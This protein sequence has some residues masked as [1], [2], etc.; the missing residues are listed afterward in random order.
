MNGVT[1]SATREILKLT[2]LPEM[3]SF[4]GGLPATECLP[5]KEVAEITADILGGSGAVSALQYGLSEGVPVFRERLKG[6]LSDVGITF[7]EKDDLF[8]ISGGQQG[9][10]LMCKVYL[11]KGDVVLV[12]NPT[13]LAFL[14][15][16]ATYEAKVVGVKSDDNGPVLSDLEE[17]IKKYKPK[18]FY[19]VPTF[20]NPTGR[21]YTP[22][23]RRGIAELAAKYDMMVLEDDPYSRLRFEGEYVPALKSFD[24]AGKV[25]YVSSFSKI[26]S[27]GLR[28]GVLT[29][30]KDVV[31]KLVIAKQGTDLHT[32]ALSQ[33]I[34]SEYLAR[35]YLKPNVAKSLPVYRKRKDAMVA[36]LDRYMPEEFVR[37]RP[38][39]GL[40]VWGEFT[41]PVNTAEAFADAVKRNVAYV[42]GS[43]FYADGGG[44]NTLRLNYS[45]A[46]EEKIERGIKALGDMFKEKVSEVKGR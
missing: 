8:V 14:Q 28:V 4:A 44:K 33:L 20:S 39:G 22:A 21:T 31:R 38:E 13:Y 29:G 32:A 23:V 6:F 11:D 37:T 45:N 2:A 42:E 40:F 9:I 10:D 24:S 30:D 34:A 3:I 15:I 36:A 25:V 26:L 1:G 41:V 35:G 27:P 18:F 46:D 16:A 19:V 7:T 43:V 5:I 12:E 17:K